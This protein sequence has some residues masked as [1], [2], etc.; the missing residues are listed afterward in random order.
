MATMLWDQ[1]V[2]SSGLAAPTFDLFRIHERQLRVNATLCITRQ[3]ITHPGGL[4]QPD[5]CTRV[6]RLT[7]SEIAPVAPLQRCTRTTGMTP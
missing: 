1:G 6:S 7:G 2:V 5:S 4:E 3:I